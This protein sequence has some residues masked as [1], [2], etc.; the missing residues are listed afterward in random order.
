M[1]SPRR[2]AGRTSR[3]ARSGSEREPIQSWDAD[4]I[5]QSQAYS[6]SESIGQE[7]PSRIVCVAQHLRS[8]EPAERHSR[9]DGGLCILYQSNSRASGRSRGPHSGPGAS[10]AH[11]CVNAG[12][13]LLCSSICASSS[14][15]GN[16]SSL[17]S[18][19]TRGTRERPA[20]V[21]RVRRSRM[22]SVCSPQPGLALSTRRASSCPGCC[23]IDRLQTGEKGSWRRDRSSRSRRERSA[24]SRCGAIRER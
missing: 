22:F 17:P 11:S 9:D 5:M 19:T 4:E 15:A 2:T 13:R 7:E 16:E 18:F 23:P 1:A 20:P 21:W 3:R 6:E 24:A 14:K 8:E 12:E 10:A